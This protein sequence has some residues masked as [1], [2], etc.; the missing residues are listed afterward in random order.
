[1][2]DELRLEQATLPLGVER[3]G[4]GR[5]VDVV[6]A[7][8]AGGV[9]VG[10]FGHAFRCILLDPLPDRATELGRL[11]PEVELHQPSSVRVTTS[12]SSASTVDPLT[13][14]GFASIV[15]RRG[16]SASAASANAATALAT[17]ATSAGAVPRA[18]PS[19]AA[20]RSSPSI[21]STSSGPT[22]SARR[23]TSRSTS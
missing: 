17:A 2:T 12:T 13:H 23:L 4:V 16:P 5:G 8:H 1:W 6:P 10:Q 22:G 15:C 11:R 7:G 21:R 19:T 14:N 20:P 18:P 9:P 3:T